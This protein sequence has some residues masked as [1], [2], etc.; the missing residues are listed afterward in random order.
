[1]TPPKV[2][3]KPLKVFV[4][5]AHEDDAHRDTLA[6]HLSALVKEGLIEIWHD[7][8]IT[9]G[10]EWAGDID[11]AL[12]SAD[13]VLL[14]IS[15]DFLD[16]DYCNDVELEEAMRLHDAAQ[17]RVVPVI[18]R[19]CDWEH[20]RFARLNALPADGQPAVE[21]QHPDQRFSAVAKGLRKVVAELLAAPQ[22]AGEAAR[23]VL[24]E[25]TPTAGAAAG[26]APPH[27]PAQP[28]TAKD[29]AG[30]GK[31]AEP[32]K[33]L[34]LTIGKIALFGLELGPIEIPLPRLG[35]RVV[36]RG[37][38]V[39]LGLALLA[40]VG[41]YAVL[42]HGP[43]SQAREAM[44]MAQYDSA[45]ESLDK[46]PTWL[47]LWPELVAARGAAQ[48]GV[49]TYQPNPD[50]EAIGRDLRR[51]RSAR[52]D[53]VDLIVLEAQDRLR[54]NDYEQVRG[55]A[56]AAAKA[57]PHNAEAWFLLGLVE[58]LSGNLERALD[59]YRRSVDA[60]PDS[61]QYRNNLARGYL[62]LGRYDDAIAEFQKIRQFPLARVEQ[63]LAHW[64]KGELHRAADAQREALAMLADKNQSARFYNRRE[65]VFFLPHTGV[66]LGLVG[67][68]CYAS[69]GEAA[70]R[71]L[72]GEPAAFPPA[73]CPDVPQDIRELLAD[74]LCRFVDAPQP[75]LAAVASELRSTLGMPKECR[76]RGIPPPLAV[77]S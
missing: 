58:D 12:G 48:L 61:P 62:D 28:E 71:R 4:S 2:F 18:L 6:R 68:R 1:M 42:L 13:I 7:R 77:S 75:A 21:A 60:A 31:A 63:A 67:K 74:N 76:P 5:Y 57:D 26:I 16:S 43:L 70:S 10:R 17:A 24:V 22:A 46:I 14:L 19:S 36:L 38:A 41:A 33:R 47:A 65:W 59:P 15:A 44:R 29:K 73:Q 34:K 3:A 23:G 66:G 30:D 64:A 8:K 52:P 11:A 40:G 69:L 49:R 35:G 45:L 25:P 32:P 56:A 72:A 37:F 55:L 9:G 20:S 50:W 54:M 53:D 27:V 39:L 51:Q